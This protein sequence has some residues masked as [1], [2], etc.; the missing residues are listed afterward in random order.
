MSKRSTGY[1]VYREKELGEI[2]DAFWAVLFICI[3]A[4]TSEVEPSKP[5]NEI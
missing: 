1:I 5:I 3:I 4:S 2:F